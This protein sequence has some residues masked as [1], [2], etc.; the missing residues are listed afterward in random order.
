[1]TPREHYEAAEKALDDAKINSNPE[2]VKANAATAQAH[3]SAVEVGLMLDA[4]EEM[5]G[6]RVAETV[7]VPLI[8]IKPRR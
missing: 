1:M 6:P 7:E 4:V 8:K 5:Q 2:W 3:L